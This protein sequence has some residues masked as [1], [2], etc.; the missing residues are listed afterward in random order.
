MELAGASRVPDPTLVRHIYDLHIMREHFDPA[1][2][3]TLACDIAAADA[4]EFRNQ[5]GAYESDAAGET[6]KELAAFREDAVYSRRY[7]EFVA[8]M[9]Y[10][11]RPAYKNALATVTFLA[12]MALKELSTPVFS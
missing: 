11:E 8:A 6:R 5:Y 9:V 12:E 7:D 10:G 2:V 3:A 4:R 1:L